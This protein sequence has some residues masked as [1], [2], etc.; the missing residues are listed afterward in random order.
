MLQRMDIS[1]EKILSLL[2]AD[3]M[4]QSEI[5]KELGC[6]QP[7]VCDLLSGKIGRVRP[8]YKIVVNLMALAQKRGI[9]VQSKKGNARA[10]DKK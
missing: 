3:G 4:T 9:P 8:S 6:S 10:R 7:T 1:I 5:A 2:I